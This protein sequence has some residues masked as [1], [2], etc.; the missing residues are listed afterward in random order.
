MLVG[1]NI[2][3]GSCQQIRINPP[4]AHRMQARGDHFMVGRYELFLGD[5]T[6]GTVDVSREGLYYRFRARCRLT[7]AVVCRAA[8]VCGNV[9][10]SLGV[11]VPVGSAEFGLDTRLPCKRFSEGKPKFLA[12]PRHGEVKGKFVPISPEEPFRYLQRLKDA[13]MEV[14]NGQV[15]VVIK[16]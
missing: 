2:G 3:I 8:V 4:L 5:Q 16:E 14:R 6:I 11:M 13:Y 15:G 1:A 7:G 12:L 10:E 9:Q